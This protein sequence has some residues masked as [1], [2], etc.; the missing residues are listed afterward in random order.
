M[1]D[2]TSNLETLKNAI[3]EGKRDLAVESTKAALDL[4]ADPT[5]ILNGYMIPALDVVGAMFES[6]E[7]FVPEMMI[8]AKAMKASLELVKPL[9]PR[10]DSKKKGT[11]VI[12][13]VYGDLHDIGKNLVCLMLDNAGYTVVDLGVNVPATKFIEEATK[14]HANVIG[15]SSLLTTGDPYIKSTIAAIRGADALKDVKIIAGGAA[16]TDKLVRTSGGDMYVPDAGTAVPVV[17]EL[18]VG[19]VLA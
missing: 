2:A 13:T 15:L 5:H 3:I 18:L 10:D 16:V 8:S 11:V 6:K 4:G 9:L 17:K 19:A 12:G 1:T 7:I 14:H